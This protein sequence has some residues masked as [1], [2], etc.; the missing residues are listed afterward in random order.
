LTCYILVVLVRSLLR[1]EVHRALR[2]EIVTGD[3]AAGEVLRDADLA[4]RFGTSKEPVRAAL[5]LLRSEGF[6]QTRPQSG[7][8][9]APLDEGTA[10]DAVDIVRTLSIRAAE[11]ALPKLTD[12][13]I[14]GMSMANDRFERAAATGDLEAALAA[15]DDF[16]DV[17][18]GLA[19]NPALARIVR[20]QT[21]VLRRLEIAQFGLDGGTTS[22]ERHR[23]LV[24]AS[25]A[26]DLP[27]VLDLTGQVWSSLADHLSK[28]T[29]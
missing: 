17:F 24:V 13:V 27:A 29:P 8:R 19:G 6:V 26:R 3:L 4:A 11:L 15:D 12:D 16:H 21:D 18:L 14:A 7:T 28:G 9:V 25:R 23:R 10:R 22:A 5:Q 2:R 20:E 1:D